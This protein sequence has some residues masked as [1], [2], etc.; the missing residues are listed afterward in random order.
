MTHCRASSIAWV[1]LMMSV[2]AAAAPA[3]EPTRHTEVSIDGGSFLINGR[4]TSEGVTWL[5]GGEATK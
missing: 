3:A 4:L 5:H 2:L 1:A